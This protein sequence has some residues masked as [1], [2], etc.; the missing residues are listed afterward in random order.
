MIG[1]PGKLA[2]K[3]GGANRRRVL[4]SRAMRRKCFIGDGHEVV[5]RFSTRSA[6]G[7]DI[8][9]HHLFALETKVLQD[10]RFVQKSRRFLP[11]GSRQL[12]LGASLDKRGIERA[13]NAA[14]SYDDTLTLQR[15]LYCVNTSVFNRELWYTLITLNTAVVLCGSLLSCI[16]VRIP[17][18]SF[19]RT[20]SA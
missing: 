5:G 18:L 13:T 19:L 7:K 8:F 9:A 12:D 20:F 3:S 15:I 6:A 16:D 2:A 14:K 4:I 1:L 17:A 11:K 10:D